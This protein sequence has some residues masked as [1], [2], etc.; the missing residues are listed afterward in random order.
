MNAQ[1]LVKNTEQFEKSRLPT[2]LEDAA[3]ALRR[4]LDFLKSLA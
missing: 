4:E 3:L 1:T 2:D